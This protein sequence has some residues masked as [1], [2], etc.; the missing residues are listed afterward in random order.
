MIWK[1]EMERQRGGGRGWDWWDG[2]ILEQEIMSP[3][4][5]LPDPETPNSHALVSGEGVN[6]PNHVNY[7]VIMKMCPGGC[8]VL[9]NENQ[10]EP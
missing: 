9:G 6:E 5:P 7:R 2:F 4:S 10:Q 1:G 8:G 3:E